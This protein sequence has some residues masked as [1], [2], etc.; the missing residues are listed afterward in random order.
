MLVQS[1]AS[2]PTYS[3]HFPNSTGLRATLVHPR[4]CLPQRP[5]LSFH[6]MAFFAYCT[7]PIARLPTPIFRTVSTFQNHLRTSRSL[8]PLPRRDHS[9]TE[10]AA[11]RQGRN[12]NILVVRFRP[13]MTSSQVSGDA[14]I[15][16]WNPYFA[17]SRRLF[18]SF[19]L[20]HRPCDDVGRHFSR[21]PVSV[22]EPSLSIPP[23]PLIAHTLGC[24]LRK[25]YYYTIALPLV[26]ENGRY[27]SRTA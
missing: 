4:A 7:V 16:S 27:F 3:T 8:P 6:G 11:P 23:Y 2:K 21:L 24:P 22:V 20:Q 5:A 12:P 9:P 15:Y 10:S 19:G 13:A 25:R 14:S 17:V 1:N 26:H 18:S